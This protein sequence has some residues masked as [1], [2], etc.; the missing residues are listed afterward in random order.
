MFGRGAANCRAGQFQVC[1]VGV[2]QREKQVLALPNPSR[3]EMEK[4]K[5]GF[6]VHVD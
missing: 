1:G 3:K 5:L 4:Q 2:Q 6:V